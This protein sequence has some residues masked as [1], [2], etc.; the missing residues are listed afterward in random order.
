MRACIVRGRP[1]RQPAGVE[2]CLGPA[3]GFTSKLPRSV[4]RSVVRR[5]DGCRCFPDGLLHRHRRVDLSRHLAGAARCPH[6]AYPGAVWHSQTTRRRH[7]LG[8]SLLG[9][10][11]SLALPVSQQRPSGNR[12]AK[13][14]RQFPGRSTVRSLVHPQQ[15]PMPAPRRGLAAA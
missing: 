13:P 9:L 4:F 12:L 11:A 5:V 14:F 7:R 8:T 10:R 15:N 1:R 6:P 2:A 3:H